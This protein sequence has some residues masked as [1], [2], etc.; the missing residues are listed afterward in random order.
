MYKKQTKTLA[1]DHLTNFTRESANKMLK[2][3]I[4][5]EVADF[6]LQHKNLKHEGKQRIIRNGYLPPRKISSGVGEIDIAMPRI[7]DRNNNEK[8]QFV[9]NLIP[10]YMRRTVSLDVI[11]PILYLKGISVNNFQD[12]LCPILGENVNNIS[13]GVIHKLKESW[14]LEYKQWLTRDL[15]DKKY[16]YFWVDGVYL[17]A[18]M[19]NEKTCMLVI[20][21]ADEFGNKEL[22]ALIDG[23]RESKA[24]WRELLLDLRSRGLVYS[25]HL[26]V[27]DGALGF[28][29]ALTEV[30]PKTVHQRCWVH[31]T[32]NVLDKLPKQS[33]AKAKSMLHDIYLAETK[34]DAIAA[35]EKFIKT[36]KIKYPKATECLMTDQEE[37]MA[38]FAF[39]AE[40]WQHIRTT[41]PIESTFATVK[42]RTRQSRGCFSRDTIISS[43]LKLLLEAEK[44]WKRLYGYTQLAEIINLVK[45]V[46][47]LPVQQEAA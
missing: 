19:D 8:I 24:A 23:V 35:Y 16:V 25:P 30:Y 18:R 36:Y 2:I 29:G 20:V 12:V 27:G 17:Q 10:K 11:L 34:K 6:I 43:T 4:E 46:D 21:G 28:W 5:Q 42:H 13:P 26:A 1:K 22:V 14:L 39:P 41:N 37:L 45:F 9:S 38:F 33:Q 7:R 15:T 3:A 47:G 32:A 31:K 40:H 44:R